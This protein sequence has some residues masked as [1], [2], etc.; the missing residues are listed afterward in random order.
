MRRLYLQV[1][2]AFLGIFALFAVLLA[3]AWH[4]A[5]SSG[6]DPQALEGVAALAAE[7]LRRD[8]PAADQQ[9]LLRRVARPAGLDLTL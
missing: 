8:S 3:L 6:D 4:S 2:L 7:L 9:A 5:P 1:Y